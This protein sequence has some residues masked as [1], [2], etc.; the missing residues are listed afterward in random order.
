MATSDDP[1]A[2]GVQELVGWK[3]DQTILE[4]PFS[5]TAHNFRYY[6]FDLP[7]G[8]DHVSIMGQFAVTAEKKAEPKPQGKTDE[9]TAT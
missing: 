8:S 1:F 6:K 4:T 5:V 9:T 2:Q 7:E 3:H